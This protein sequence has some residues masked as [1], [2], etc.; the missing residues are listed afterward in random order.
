MELNFTLPYQQAINSWE[1]ILWTGIVVVT[2]TYIGYGVLLF[3]MV[4]MKQWL[5]PEAKFQF[6]RENL[7]TVTF[8]V[9][10]Y[11]EEDYIEDKI[12]NS[13]QV[14]YPKDKIE[15]WFVTDGSNDKTVDI[16]QQYSGQVTSW[17][18][19][20]RAGKIAAMHR[21]MQMVKSDIAIFSDANAMLNIEAVMEIV[22]CYANPK[23]GAVAGEKGIAMAAEEQ[24]SGAGE[25]IY[26]KYESQLKKW[27]YQ[28]YSVVGAAGELFSVRTSLY[29]P[30]PSDTLLDD[31]MISLKIAAKGYRVA[32]A[33]EAKA[34]EQASLNV[35]EE[36]KRKVRISA[37]GLQSI[38]RLGGLL[39]IFKHGLLSFQYISHRVLRWTLAPLA[40]PLILVSNFFLILH[41][42]EIIYGVLFNAQLAFY[43]LAF[44]G[45]ILENKKIKIKGFFVPY[46]FV[47]MNLS[48]YMG[49]ARL[50]K[51]KQSVKWDKAVRASSTT[52]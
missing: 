43:F 16:V 14:D 33:P 6:T 2:Y 30:V 25:G 18:S 26:W 35:E 17:H 50:L 48:V 20:E 44:L 29:E 15:F 34:M 37:G 51:G 39:N 31:F 32:Y 40:L 11:N 23:V 9:A 46:Y 22:Q 4:K 52:P 47:M 41:E 5:R 49:V 28:L 12:L 45:K 27:D 38:Y 21:A 19:D 13:L 42:H 7:P 36:M 10:A 3:F 24:A 8:I 1:I